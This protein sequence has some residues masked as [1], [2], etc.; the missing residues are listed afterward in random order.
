[1][2]AIGLG[3]FLSVLWLAAC[4]GDDGGSPTVPVNPG[5]DG[6]MDNDDCVD[7]DGD[8]AGRRCPG[9]FDCNDDDPDVTDC[10]SCNQP[11]KDCPCEEGTDPMVCDPDNLGEEMVVN[12]QL[13]ECTE[14]A[15]YCQEAA[16]VEETW[17]WT[18]CVGVF[19]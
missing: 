16:G 18:D 1:M 10:T 9:G 6:G 14:G 2:R 12:G 11:E 4:G 15:R 5:D 19:M 13:L 7:N 8:G 3:M 17:V